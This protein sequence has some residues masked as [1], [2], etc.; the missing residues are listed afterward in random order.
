MMK[1]STH[2]NYKKEWLYSHVYIFWLLSCT[3]PQRDGMAILTLVL[4]KTTVGQPSNTDGTSVFGV[5]P[6][7]TDSN[8]AAI[9]HKLCF[10]KTTSSS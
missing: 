7:S 1:I 8:T 3:Q 2:Y 10:I 9:Q 5:L 6:D 4:E